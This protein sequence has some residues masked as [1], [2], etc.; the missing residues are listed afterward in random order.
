MNFNK[1]TAASGELV[2]FLGFVSIGDVKVSKLWRE[3]VKSLDGI[4]KFAVAINDT[5]FVVLPFD[6]E[7]QV[8]L[9]SI[10]YGVEGAVDLPDASPDGII[11][12]EEG[13]LIC[14]SSGIIFLIDARKNSIVTRLKGPLI[15]QAI[16]SNDVDC[17]A[18]LSKYSIILADRSLVHICTIKERIPIKSGAWDADVDVF[19]YTTK[20]QIKYCHPNGETWIIKTL[21]KPAYIIKV[22]KDTIHCLD[23]EC[24]VIPIP[25]DDT[26]YNINIHLL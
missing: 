21:D 23:K 5:H 17:V 15:K 11:Y 8:E 7:K 26:E 20:T 13:K 24:T 12:G 19:V 18:L 14:S 10:T 22:S 16:W 2:L 9:H 6:L 3:T 4:G 1:F 25:F